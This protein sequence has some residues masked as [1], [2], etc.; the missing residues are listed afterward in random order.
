M[1]ADL[2]RDLQL[3]Q[4]T[5][6]MQINPAEIT[7]DSK[8]DLAL[9][10]KKAPNG[11]KVI[12]TQHPTVKASAIPSQVAEIKTD[13]PQVEV[14]ASSPAPSESPTP[15]APPMARPAPMPAPTYPS[16]GSIP[17]AGTG[18]G[19][20]SGGMGG[21]LGGIFGAIIGGGGI[22]DDDHCDP[23]P[24]GG[25]NTGN[26]GIY[27]PIGGYPTGGSRYPTRTPTGGSR[28]PTRP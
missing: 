4:T 16:T 9:R 1:S 20:A 27:H 7:P 19:R 24:R 15:D 3:A 25:R 17:T 26:G 18:N 13:I 21:V 11:P 23:R 6:N 2:K 28:Y 8:Q 14:A 22:G 5:Q 12:R 10:P